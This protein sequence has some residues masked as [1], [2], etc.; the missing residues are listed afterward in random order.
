MRTC[1][2]HELIEK[3]DKDDIWAPRG[4]KNIN[5]AHEY[6]AMADVAA[7]DAVCFYVGGEESIPDLDAVPALVRLP[8]PICWFEF[9]LVGSEH[10]TF[11]LLATE[12]TWFVFGR[13]N[14]PLIWEFCGVGV[15]EGAGDSALRWN[16]FPNISGPYVDLVSGVMKLT[17]IFLSAM[18]C[19]NVRQ[20]EHLPDEKLQR[21]RKKRGKLPLFS[22]WTLELDLTKGRSNAHG[23]GTHASPRVH[24]RRGHARQYAP[25]KWTWV[26]PCAVGSVAAGIVHKEYALKPGGVQ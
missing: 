21:A 13:T 24:L 22:F 14:N 17:A 23:D 19:S 10:Y 15:R 9:V 3:F 18:N 26:Q 5:E 8:F 1:H 7:R 16:I 11:G 4:Y 25:G 12:T 2:L 6:V 20:V